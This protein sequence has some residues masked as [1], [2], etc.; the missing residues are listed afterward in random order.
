MASF[1]QSMKFH[2]F[3]LVFKLLSSNCKSPLTLDHKSLI[4]A[5]ELIIT[6]LTLNLK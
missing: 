3:T 4:T 6:Y 2:E 1:Y 5:S